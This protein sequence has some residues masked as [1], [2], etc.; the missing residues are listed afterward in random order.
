MSVHPAYFETRFRVDAAPS[1][2]PAEFVILSAHATTGERWPDVENERAHAALLR[3]LADLGVWM[4][5]LT[6]FSPT[7]GHAEPSVAAELDLARARAIG[8]RFRQDAIYHVR[9]DALSVTRCG[10]ADPLVPVGSFAAR[11]VVGR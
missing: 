9:D 3:E 11:V 6:G 8:R 4:L 1:A 10:E 5:Q 2:W 7:T